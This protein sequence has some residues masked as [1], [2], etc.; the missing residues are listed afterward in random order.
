MS[1]APFAQIGSDIDGEAAGDQSG[2]SVSLSADG[3]IVA[4]G[5]LSNWTAVSSTIYTATFTPKADSTTNGV[6]SVASN[7]FSDAAFPVETNGL[8]VMTSAL[9][10]CVSSASNDLK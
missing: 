6:I 3:S 4:I 2:E 9:F 7:Q 10:C 5:S 1:F 8:Q